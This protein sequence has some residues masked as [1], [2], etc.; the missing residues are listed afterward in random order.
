M[1]LACRCAWFM[2][3]CTDHQ[4]VCTAHVATWQ[5][6][7]VFFF[8]FGVIIMFGLSEAQVRPVFNSIPRASVMQVWGVCPPHKAG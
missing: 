2:L 6:A 1:R 7:D 4:Q 5:A 3:I 8:D